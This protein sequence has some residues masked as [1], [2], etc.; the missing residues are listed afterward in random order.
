MMYDKIETKK[1]RTGCF[2]V[3][4]T[5]GG[6]E[7]SPSRGRWRGKKLGAKGV[8]P[9]SRGEFKI[10]GSL[11]SRT[12]ARFLT[13]KDSDLAGVC[14]ERLNNRV[15]FRPPESRQKRRKD[16]LH[17]SD[18]CDSKDSRNSEGSVDTS[19]YFL[20]SDPWTMM[21]TTRAAE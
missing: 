2:V 13:T 12:R 4:S 7:A 3:S 21:G 15:V 19:F 6:H 20:L 10:Q 9:R 17:W 11:G 14:R 16:G 5:L 8:S 1:R 18:S